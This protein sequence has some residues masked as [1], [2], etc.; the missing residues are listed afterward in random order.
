MKTIALIDYEGTAMEI[1]TTERPCSRS[2]QPGTDC[3]GTTNMKNKWQWLPAGDLDVVLLSPAVI[4]L[5]GFTACVPVAMDER[6]SPC[7]DGGRH[8]AGYWITKAETFEEAQKLAAEKA[9]EI[10][11]E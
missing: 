3:K 7:D 8:F 2:R 9:Q 6:P 1:G 4:W 10:V 5:N 11:P